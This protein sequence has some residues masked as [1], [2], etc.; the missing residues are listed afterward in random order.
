M[1]ILSV[2][3][4]PATAGACCWRIR[5]GDAIAALKLIISRDLFDG[6]LYNVVT[7]NATV[8]NIVDAISALIPDASLEY[9]NSPIMNQLSYM[10][11]NDRFANLG[12]TFEGNLERGIGDT[13]ALLKGARR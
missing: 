1:R 6:G 7:A 5:L 8:R 11:R 13:I 4:S 3:S 10:V 12:F 9:V 2:A